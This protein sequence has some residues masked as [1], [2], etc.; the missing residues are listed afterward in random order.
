MT[1]NLRS[2]IG[3]TLG[4]GGARGLAHIGVLK[5]L[6]REQIPIGAI[7]GTS[8]GGIIGA[9]YAAGKSAADIEAE[10][11]RHGDIGQI[12]KL[13]DVRFLGS[14]LLKGKRVKKLLAEMLGAETTFADLR[15]PLAVIAVDY[16]SGR[17]MVL[18]T[19]RLVDAVRATMSVP[20]IFEPV[21]LGGCQLLDGGVLDNV[22]VGTARSLGADKII[23]VDVLPNFRLNEPGAE[24]LVPPLK[25]RRVPREYRQLWHIELIMIAA[26]TEFRL[27]EAQPEVIIRPDLP[28]DMDLLMSF[29]RPAEAIAIGEQ[30]AEAALPQI[31]ALLSA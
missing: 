23:A 21:E 29:D 24:I 2:T 19:G 26:I 4:G 9:L 18:K 17:E 22:P 10:A 27:K 7:A 11:R 30:A 13:V 31:R 25:P 15:V 6:E 20:G 14:G 16:N 5:V 1:K 28:V 3:L 12:F 8:M